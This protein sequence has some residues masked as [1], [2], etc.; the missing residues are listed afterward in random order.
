VAHFPFPPPQ[1][2]GYIIIDI[3]KMLMNKVKNENSTQ[4]RWGNMHSRYFPIAQFVIYHLFKGVNIS[5][6]VMA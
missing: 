4:M 5:P 2:L 3:K 1:A 6:R